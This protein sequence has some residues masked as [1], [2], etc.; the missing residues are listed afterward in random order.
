MVVLPLSFGK[1]AA[2]RNVVEIVT[3]RD[4]APSA[5]SIIS[6]PSTEEEPRGC[7]ASGGEMKRTKSRPTRLPTISTP[8]F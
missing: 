4:K 1:K 6:P 3:P 5:Q 8:A 7:V 2:E